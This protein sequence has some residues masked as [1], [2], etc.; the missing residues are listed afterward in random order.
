MLPWVT[1]WVSRIPADVQSGGAP[2]LI[3]SAPGRAGSPRSRGAVGARRPAPK[4]FLERFSSGRDDASNRV[5]EP[6]RRVRGRDQ[7][8]RS[9]R[10]PRLRRL[11][12]PPTDALLHDADQLLVDEL[13][14]PVRPELASEA[15]TLNTPERQFGAVKE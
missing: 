4:R 5:G 3:V 7:H 15:G 8:R 14:H 12:N 6:P 9:D 13:V 11:A 2:T 10:T 1:T